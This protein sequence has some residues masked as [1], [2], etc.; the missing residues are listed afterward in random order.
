MATNLTEACRLAIMTLICRA[1]ST[2]RLAP[3]LGTLATTPGS[4]HGGRGTL[5]LDDQASSPQTLTAC[6][7]API[8][9]ADGASNKSY[10]F[11]EHA[12][13]RTYDQWFKPK[14]SRDASE[15]TIRGDHCHF[16]CSQFN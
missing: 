1:D 14:Y 3:S 12:V 6:S 2:L 8:W 7:L 16:T 11:I 13:Q 15:S 5:L 9:Q 4:T 10:G